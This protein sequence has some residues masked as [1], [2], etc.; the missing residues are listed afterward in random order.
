[1]A[2]YHR[3]PVMQAA[4]VVGALAVA[5]PASAATML[6]DMMDKLS[7]VAQRLAKVPVRGEAAA[8]GAASSGH[9]GMSD[10]LRRSMVN[11]N[12]FALGVAALLGAS[13]R[14]CRQYPLFL[15]FLHFVR[16]FL[17][18]EFWT[19]MKPWAYCGYLVFLLARH[20][21]FLLVTKCP[22]AEASRPHWCRACF[23]RLYT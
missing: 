8:A 21:G 22:F 5:E 1:M 17:R 4:S 13:T 19:S 6:R 18:S 2:N 11:V 10:T 16:L 15:D 20:I 23:Y 14:C 9:G 12:G 3:P 7:L